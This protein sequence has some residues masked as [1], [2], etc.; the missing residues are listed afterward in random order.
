MEAILDMALRALESAEKYHYDHSV[1]AQVVRPA[2]DWAHLAARAVLIDLL[3]RAGIKHTLASVDAANRAEIIEVIAEIARQAA[4]KADILATSTPSNAPYAGWAIVEL[5]GKSVLAGHINEQV[6]FGS[7][8]LRVDVPATNDT[9][10]FTKFYGG[11]SIYA[12]TPTDEATAKQAVANLRVRPVTE[13]VVPT[14]RR[15]I[16][17]YMGQDTGGDDEDDSEF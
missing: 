16:A 11:G 1:G 12:I 14:A 2:K 7:S 6:M 3:D 17:V 8:L 4:L 13:W 15:Q 9:P 10:G 5:M